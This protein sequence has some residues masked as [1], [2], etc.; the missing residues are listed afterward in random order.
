MN[1][2]FVFFGTDEVSIGVLNA[3]ETGGFTPNLIIT[4]T[5]QPVG[6]KQ[7][8][9]PPPVK[10]WAQERNIP[11]LQPEKFKEI[12]NWPQKIAG[13]DFAIVASYGKIIPKWVLDSFPKGVLNVHPS[14]LPM[15]RGPTPFQTALLDDATETGVTI[16]LMDEEMDHGNIID[17]A[18]LI[19]QSSDTYA[20]L[21][22]KL[23]KI[24]GEMLAEIIPKWLA[25]EITPTE[26][27]HE[28]ATYTRK[29]TNEDG[30][31]KPETI[32]GDSTWTPSVQ[33]KEVT[34]A[35]RQIRALNPEPGTWTELS[36][37]TGSARRMKI[38]S[39]RIDNKKLVP[40]RVIPS[41]KKE[42]GWEDF[43]RGMQN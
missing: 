41:G 3:L 25:G 33:V 23:S 18:K 11:V 9:T 43:L 15:Y 37:S 39:A 12:E 29:F 34:Y 2:N 21:A 36:N 16:M 28:Q 6:R 1:Q 5:D 30:F 26:Q 38:L 4:R 40:I 13:C 17:S 27:N 8:T 14:L 32:F 7:I 31:I 42:M 35:D 24:G 10:V 19:I 22:E 20:T